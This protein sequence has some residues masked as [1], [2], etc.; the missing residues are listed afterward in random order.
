MKLQKKKGNVA[1]QEGGRAYV[2]LFSALLDSVRFDTLSAGA[3]DS[4]LLT[5]KQ[6]LGL[7]QICDKDDDDREEHVTFPYT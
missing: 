6:I 7:V 3:K 4:I 2:Q 5:K 1:V